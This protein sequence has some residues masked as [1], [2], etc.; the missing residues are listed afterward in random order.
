MGI[1]ASIME[2][3]QS[4][5]SAVLSLFPHSPFREAINNFTPPV[6]LKWFTWFFPVKNCLAILALWLVAISAFYLYSI[7]ARWVKLLGD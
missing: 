4:V 7:I 5:L 2:F 3:L 1:F 6:Y